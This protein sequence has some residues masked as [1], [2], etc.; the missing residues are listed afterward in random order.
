MRLE[1]FRMFSEP[2]RH[3]PR[4][5]DIAEG[6]GDCRAGRHAAARDSTQGTGEG[7]RER[8]VHERITSDARKTF[9][10][11]SASTPHEI[12]PVARR[13]H[14]DQGGGRRRLV[15]GGLGGGGGVG[16]GGKDGGFGGGGVG[17]NGR[18]GL[19]GVGWEGQRSEL[20]SPRNS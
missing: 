6:A 16:G 17:L 10:R 11:N 15:G 18:R 20:R 5:S 7:L 1:R 12:A 2:C 19:S 14:R 13:N 8:R 9:L 4:G 3:G